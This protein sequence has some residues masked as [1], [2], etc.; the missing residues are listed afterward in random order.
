MSEPTNAGLD[1]QII[2]QDEIAASVT[3]ALEKPKQPK[4]ADVL[5]ELAEEADL[6]HTPANEAF[7]DI[8]INGHRET[9]PIR[10]KGFRRWLAQRFFQTQKSAP[11]SEALQSALNVIEAKAHFNGPERPVHLRVAGLDDKLYIDLGDETWRVIEI[12]ETGWQV[13]NDPP[14]RFR[15]AAGLLPLPQPELGGSIK[16]L[17]DFLNLSNDDD[18]VL[19]IAWLLAALRNRGPY[20]V[21]VLSGEQGSA[22][23]TFSA[24]LRALIDPNAAP[25]RALPR[26]DRDLF[27]AATNGHILCFDNVSGLQT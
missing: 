20:P 26:E 25:L 7:A 27:I 12:D 4:Q 11:N 3:K 15:R 19:V 21:L 24:L 5:I 16:T 10:S 2:D 13:I 17:R 6:F 8:H 1:Q 22:K 14:V 23:S 18:F 9:R